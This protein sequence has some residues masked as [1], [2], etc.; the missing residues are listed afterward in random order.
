MKGL[1]SQSCAAPHTEKEDSGTGHDLA[2]PLREEEEN[3]WRNQFRYLI[4]DAVD[5]VCVRAP[6]PSSP[7]SELSA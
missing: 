3:G 4:S 6:D 1:E 2:P 7:F 5:K